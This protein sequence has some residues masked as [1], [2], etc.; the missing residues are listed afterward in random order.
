M[1]TFNTLSNKFRV[2]NV[3]DAQG[4]LNHIDNLLTDEACENHVTHELGSLS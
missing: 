3:S 4:N 2:R 1:Q